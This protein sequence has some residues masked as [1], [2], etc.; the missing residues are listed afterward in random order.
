MILEAEESCL[1][2]SFTVSYSTNR[3]FTMHK[4]S[5]DYGSEKNIVIY[6]YHIA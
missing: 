1:K 6:T 4:S 3:I 2:G 5:K